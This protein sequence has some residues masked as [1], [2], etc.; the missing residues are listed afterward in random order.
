[1][2]RFISLLVCLF[3]TLTLGAWSK[4]GT[5]AWR[6]IKNPPASPH[7]TF[8]NPKAGKIPVALMLLSGIGQR[9]AIELQQRFEYRYILLPVYDY[10]TFSPFAGYSTSGKNIRVYGQAM[11]ADEYKPELE[12]ILKQLPECDLIV[13]GKIQWTNIPPAVQQKFLERVKAGASMLV[14][15][16]DGTPAALPEGE[17][18]KTQIDFPADAVPLL[19]DSVIR[20]GE[21]GRG[22]IMAVD[23][24]ALKQKLPNWVF[25]ESITPFESDDPLYYELSLAFIAK[26]MMVLTEPYAPKVTTS[27][28]DSVSVH[29]LPAGSFLEYSVLDRFGRSVTSFKVP[30]TSQSRGRFHAE[31][32]PASAAMV[33]VKLLDSAN[34]TID[35]T[36]LPV[37]RKHAEVVKDIALAKDIYYPDE[38]IPVKLDFAALF[39]GDIALTLT[40]DRS[41]VIFERTFAVDG[42]SAAFDLKV[43]H[44]LSRYA[45]ISVKALKNG[46]VVDEK[47]KNIYFNTDRRGK[48]DD[49]LFGM[50]SY[51]ISNSRVNSLWLD[52][53][54]KE[55]ID[56]VMCASSIYSPESK[57]A[58]TP[59]NI[60][61]HGMDYASYI[62]RLSAAVE[63]RLKRPCPFAYFEKFQQTG[64]LT[65]EKGLPFD[66][67]THFL[68]WLNVLKETGVVFY[69]LG[70]ENHLAFVMKD[71]NCFCGNCQRRFREYLKKVYG[72]LD[73]VN[74]S[75]LSSYKSFD[76]IVAAPFEK[77][78]KAGHYSLWLDYRLFMEEEFVKWHLYK[79]EQIRAVD[80]RHRIG[81]EGMVYPTRFWQGYNLPKMLKNFDFCAPYFN[82][83]DVHA[84]KYTAP[85]ALKSA[86]F[87]TY[88]T[89]MGSEQLRQ[90]VWHYLFAGL[91]GVFY[92]FSGE[93]QNTNSF[94]TACITGPDLAPL[95]Q[96]TVPAKEVELIRSS[97]IGKLLIN[98]QAV[99]DGIWIHYSNSSMLASVLAPDKNTWELSVNEFTALL[100]SIGAGYD[101]ATPD[102]TIKGIP[103]NIKVLILPYALAMSD[104]ECAAVEKFVSRGGMVIADHDPAVMD[105]HAK[106]RKKSPLLKVFGNFDKFHVSKYGKGYAA[107]L[108]GFISGA[109]SRIRKGEA[110][111]I[112]YAMLRLLDKANVRP[113]A[114]ITDRSGNIAGTMVFKHGSDRY[115]TLLAQ[116]SGA[117]SVVKKAAGAE[118]G[119]S[120]LSAAG[121]DFSRIVTLEKPMHVYDILQ[122]RYFG[123]VQRF[124]L[125]LAPASGRVVACLE[126][127]PAVPE[128]EAAPSSVNAGSAVQFTFGK[129]H[130][131]AILTVCDPAGKAVFIRR[132]SG[133]SARFVPAYNDA[134]GVYTAEL[135]QVI[136]GNKTAVKFTVK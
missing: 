117:D 131:T 45:Q 14:I 136:G 103:E 70:D 80:K 16:F 78:L 59:R 3:F 35:F 102:E 55:G 21:Y 22:Q 110:S 98:S 31:N 38:I 109:D 68:K 97:G 95:P 75:Y 57:M 19:K 114:R 41:K 54:R 2:K 92:W 100:D 65:D 61:R 81:I 49:F 56:F 12:K 62:T 90:T 129:I 74:K 112:Q 8:A 113:A 96:F 119:T 72:T 9:E 53:M 47:R 43:L 107:Y 128:I 88:E 118:G 116:R 105:E 83:R 15:G 99:N 123:K 10:K 84:L 26:C 40:D 34:R 127:V 69:N 50:W 33:E 13:L 29:P 24:P 134:K 125:T 1:M 104:A 111:G 7:R 60:K 23:Y 101:L 108:G 77:S 28:V 73:N 39:K 135:R 6:L 87:G 91:H 20:T 66:R 76:D 89:M 27:G 11:T 48:P 5:P 63:F 82:T 32:L 126:S 124:E 79:V 85:G 37:V 122:N 120:L 25:T 71:E 132:V 130:N 52:A 51:G 18:N 106:A 64:K 93:P 30:A 4:D 86:W 17:Y 36:F 58:F 46:T 133:N 42:N 67:D 121:G 115:L 94:T 44:Q